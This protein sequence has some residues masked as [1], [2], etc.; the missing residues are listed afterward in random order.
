MI[1]KKMIAIMQDITAI[2]KDQKNQ[3]QNFNFRGIDT[4]YNEL[5]SIFTKH[6]VYTLP[7]VLDEKSEERKT[8]KGG[9]LIY[10]VLKMQYTFVAEDGSSVECV[11]VGEGMD[12]GDKA[13]NKAMSI[14][15]K[16]C[17]LQVFMI[18]TKDLA[19]PDKESHDVMP[20][21]N[22]QKQREYVPGYPTEGDYRV[23]IFEARK[24]LIEEYKVREMTLVQAESVEDAIKAFDLTDKKGELWQIVDPQYFKKVCSGI[25]PKLDTL[26]IKPN[27]N[28]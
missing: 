23:A 13:A 18:P 4:I 8:S 21:E 6:N 17:L 22:N 25:I 10:R 2:G 14:A 12:S 1:H 7:K 16:Y 11:V 9:N 5:H 28:A 27:A 19:D 24:K 26:N 15:H 20:K 3:M